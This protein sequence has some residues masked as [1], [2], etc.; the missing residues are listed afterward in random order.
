M[1]ALSIQPTYPI[2]TDIDGQPLEAGYI[3]IGTANLNPITNPINVFFNAAL[4]QPA[5]QPIRTISGYPSN[6]GTPGRLYVNSDYSIQVQ[7]KNGTV[8]Y[9][10]PTATE[11]YSDVVV[12]GILDD[13]ANETDPAKGD[14]LIGYHQANQAGLIPNTFGRTVHDK[15]QEF[16]SVFDFMTDAE[17]QAAKT[18]TVLDMTSS[19]QNALDFTES[20]RPKYLKFPPGDYFVTQ[21]T[22]GRTGNRNNSTYDFY[23]AGISGI[24]SGSSIIQCK[25]GN[26]KILGLTLSGQQSTSYECGLHWFTNDVNTFYPGFMT[27]TDIS[28]SGCLIGFGIGALP[29][30]AVIPPIS[31][32]A[33]LPDGDAVNAPVSESFVTNL[34]ISD[35]ITCVYM[36]QPNGKLSFMQPVLNP[37][38]AQ[39]TPSPASA[40]GNLSALRLKQGELTIVG[41]EILNVNSVTGQLCSAELATLNIMGTIMESRTP[42]DISS[43]AFVRIC[44]DANWGLNNDASTFFRVSDSADGELTVSDSFLR[45]GYGTV[46]PQPVLKVVNSGGGNSVSEAFIVNFDN[47]EFGDPNFEQ[48]ST[49]KPLV[50]GCRSV[51]KNCW[52]TEHSSIDPFPRGESVKIDEK[53]NRL[54]DEVDLAS[55]TITAYGVNGNATSGGFTFAISGG[56]PSWGK[57]TV[58]LPTIEGLAVSAA[59]RLTATGAAVVLQA[60]STLFGVQPQRPYLLKGY[61][62]TGGSGLGLRIRMNYFDFGGNPSAIDAQIDLYNGPESSFN[63]GAVWAPFMLYFVPPADTTQASLNLY[64]ENGADLQVFNL[65]IM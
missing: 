37:S 48:G 49:Y 6:A 65:E 22:I 16:V 34:Q 52:Y 25:A 38:N 44:N 10:S 46:S 40:E 59:L 2:F 31:P 19:I 5:V 41:G 62:I 9:S 4:T 20:G 60:T 63:L 61:A 43:R 30:Q 14:A 33:V 56:S 57:Y 1:S 28:I 13:L 39:W 8:V 51:F 11:R 26:N 27:F 3:F 24:G 35:C 12:S 47:V 50:S 53:D 45:R 42:I 32:P 17:I 21:I 15:L 58:G 18:N 7:N 54:I 36:R 23:G 55:T 29:S 64:T